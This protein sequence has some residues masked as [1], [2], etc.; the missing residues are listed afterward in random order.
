MLALLKRLRNE[1]RRKRTLTGNVQVGSG[2]RFGTGSFVWAPRALTIGSNVSIGSEVRIEVDGLIGDSVLIA[3]SAAIVGK[4]DHEILNVGTPI[5]DGRWVGSSPTE[6]SRF[7]TIGSDVWIGF[8]STILSGVTIGDCSIV[9][10]GAVVTRDI[11][12]NSIVAGNPARLIRERFSQEDL[13]THWVQLEA[14]GIR[15]IV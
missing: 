11:P 8:R 15:R 6:L 7:T 10:A 3:N 13:A 5:R 9:G 4:S 12:P 2:F 14:R 1:M